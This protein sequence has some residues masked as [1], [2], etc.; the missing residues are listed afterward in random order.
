[1]DVTSRKLMKDLEAMQRQSGR[2]LRNMSLARMLS[3]ESG[4]RQPAVDIYEGEDHIYVYFDLA[5]ADQDSLSV[6][7]D[8]HQ[9][10]V[11]GAKALPSQRSIACI[12][13]LEIELGAFDRVVSLPT[14]VDVDQVSSVY[15]NGI[16]VITLPKNHKKGKV[17]I[18]IESG[19]K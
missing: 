8:E 6:I 2:M 11:S 16:L 10:R 18:T 14:S 17:R 3:M 19:D 13:Q 9:V 12:H 5:G 4:S 7:A 1:M 15:S